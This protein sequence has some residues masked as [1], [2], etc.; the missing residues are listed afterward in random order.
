LQQPWLVVKP[1][2]ENDRTTKGSFPP[3]PARQP[4]V[5]VVPMVQQFTPAQKKAE[6]FFEIAGA[7][8]VGNLLTLIT[9]KIVEAHP[10]II[11]W[12]IRAALVILLLGAAALEIVLIVMGI[13]WFLSKVY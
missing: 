8:L 1:E 9:Y 6:M 4:S 12:S 3:F 7:V 11:G 5:I 2:G 10:K 13:W